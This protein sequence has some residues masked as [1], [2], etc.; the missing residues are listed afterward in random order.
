[1]TIQPATTADIPCIVK[2]VNSAYRGE[3]GEVGWTHEGHLISGPR[4]QEAD[5]A[6]LMRG[7]GVILTGW[8]HE[9][10]AGCVYLKKEVH[11]LY[12][13]MLSV[14][15]RHQ[16]LGIGKKLM[17]AA[18]ASA[19]QQNCSVIRITVI[20]AR[21]ELIAWYERQGFRRTGEVEPFHEGDRFGT[22]KQ[23]LELVVLEKTV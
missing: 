22:V 1:M 9:E 10:L 16:G 6:E 13:G 21:G 17:A 8:E 18:A 19:V 4:T 23:P 3:A 20:S 15:P 12:L 14:S 5:V 2:L 11:R 7:G